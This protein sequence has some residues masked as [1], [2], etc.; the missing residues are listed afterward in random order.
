LTDSAISD[1]QDDDGSCLATLGKECQTDL[2]NAVQVGASANANTTGICNSVISTIPQSCN[3][4]FTG[5]SVGFQMPAK[6]LKT[7]QLP[8]PFLLAT[9]GSDGLGS[10]KPIGHDPSNLTLYDA[11]RKLVTLMVFTT[12]EPDSN[13]GGSESSSGIV[14]L[15]ANGTM[16]GSQN[17]SSRLG[18]GLGGLS[19]VVVALVLGFLV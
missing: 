11:A 15:R 13:G 7:G 1:G 8:G 3:S 19:S 5:F 18:S 14:C 16:P 17:A 10:N 12:I 6:D 4:K 9:S 2:I